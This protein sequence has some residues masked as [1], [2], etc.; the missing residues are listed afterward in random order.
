[1]FEELKQYSIV[2]NA[3][4]ENKLELEII[5]PREFTTD[6]RIDDYQYGG[7]AGMIMLIEPI[8]KALKSIKTNHSY[9]INTSPKGRTLNQDV[10]R[11]FSK[12]E[13][14]V[15]LAGHY[16]G[17]DSRIEHYINENISIGDYVLSGGEIP[18]FVIIDSIARL[19]PG[20]INAESLVNETFEGNRIEHNQY[21]KPVSFEGHDVPEVLLSGDHKKI[22]EWRKQNS[23]NNTIEYVYKHKSKK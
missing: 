22:E 1:M 16:E 5:D 21:S 14:I 23:I 6:G 4:L 7:G 10:A 8:V 3:I 17:I 15:I 9:I 19:L 11:E 18:A 12:K 13:H 20:V 2:K